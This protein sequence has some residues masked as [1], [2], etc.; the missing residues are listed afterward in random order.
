MLQDRTDEYRRPDENGK[1]E[2]TS[3]GA[4]SNDNLM[5]T[6]TSNQPE[7][8]QEAAR[9]NNSR[10]QSVTKPET[11]DNLRPEKYDREQSLEGEEATYSA[12]YRTEDNQS[13][14]N[15]T[16]RRRNRSNRYYQD[17]ES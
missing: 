17:D 4:Q 11:D 10:Y 15:P 14:M 8:P 6:R 5:S 1:R 7:M 9:E 2:S 13:A 16:S 12:S 3:D